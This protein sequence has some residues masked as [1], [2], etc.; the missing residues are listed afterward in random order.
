VVD[1]QTTQ[2]ER[3]EES[4]IL[5]RRTIS[6][7]QADRRKY[8]TGAALIFSQ[9]S[10][11]RTAMGVGQRALSAHI[12]GGPPPLLAPGRVTSPRHLIGV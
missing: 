11:C 1:M 7:R 5:V 6:Y 4:K 10:C 3:Q 9:S 8:W 12:A 2:Y